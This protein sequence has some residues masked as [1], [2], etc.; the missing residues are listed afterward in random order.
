MWWCPKRAALVEYKHSPNE[1]SLQALRAA[2]GKVQQTA[3]CANKNWQQLSNDIKTA[4]GTGNIK[5]MYEGIKCALGQ[6]QTKMP[7]PLQSASGEV[8]T[9][10]GE[11]MERWVEHF[12]SDLYSKENVSIVPSACNGGAWC[13][14]RTGWAL[15]GY[16]QLNLWQGILPDLIKCCKIPFFCTFLTS[17][18]NVGEREPYHKTWERPILSPCTIKNKGDKSD[19]NNYWGISILGIISKIL[20]VVLCSCA[21]RSC[22]RVHLPRVLL[23][24]LCRMLNSGHDLLHKNAS[25]EG[26]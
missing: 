2:R 17:S 21:C 1:K 6:T 23:Q 8:T 11:Q 4:A 19:C 9:D 15:Q 3:R 22:R 5:R 24:L 25:T 10:K 12:Y 20:S 13:R 16:R 14:S 26:V 18:A 7:P